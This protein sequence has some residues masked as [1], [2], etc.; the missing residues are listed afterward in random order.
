MNKKNELACWPKLLR[1]IEKD[2][3]KKWKSLS[4]LLE[5]DS[6]CGRCHRINANTTTLKDGQSN[7]GLIEFQSTRTVCQRCF[8]FNWFKYLFPSVIFAFLKNT[9]LIASFSCPLYHWNGFGLDYNTLYAY[10]RTLHDCMKSEFTTIQQMAN[11]FSVC[12]FSAKIA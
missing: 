1:L 2:K 10:S 5:V 8:V 12:H 6:I 7:L 3:M 9:P 11:N 4:L